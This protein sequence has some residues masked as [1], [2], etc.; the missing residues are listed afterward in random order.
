MSAPRPK[1]R[2]AT[3]KAPDGQISAPGVHG[4]QGSEVRAVVPDNSAG[5]VGMRGPDTL[6]HSQAAAHFPHPLVKAQPGLNELAEAAQLVE[7]NRGTMNVLGKGR[8]LGE[9]GLLGPNL[10][11][12]DHLETARQAVDA[13]KEAKVKT[14]MA[15][16]IADRNTPE[17][18]AYLKR[19][20]PEYDTAEKAWF[21][22]CSEQHEMIGML[23]HK[24]EFTSQ[25]EVTKIINILGG[26]TPLI[27]LGHP[28]YNVLSGEDQGLIQYISLNP[29]YG[30]FTP[31][32]RRNPWYKMY[33]SNE[34]VRKITDKIAELLLPCFHKHWQGHTS[35]DKQRDAIYENRRDLAAKELVQQCRAIVYEATPGEVLN[36]VYRQVMEG[37]PTQWR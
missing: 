30:Y 21:K 6:D 36:T 17:G 24:V 31:H 2:N 5:G 14:F 37:M 32:D 23:A 16:N 20:M 26:A 33:D 22:L 15:A 4:L 8:L 35:A 28:L 27:F 13:L 34:R 3:G 19:L 29:Y 7:M 1:G 18:R 12:T 25:E 11:R 10:H 9:Q